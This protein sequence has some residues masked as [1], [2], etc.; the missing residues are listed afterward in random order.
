MK[1][2]ISLIIVALASG[3]LLR[4]QS[5]EP[6][7]ELEF[8]MELKVKCADAFQKDGKN[9]IPIVGGVFEGPSIKGTVLPD[10][11]DTQTITQG[12]VELM[13]VYDIRTDDGVV[14]HVR[15]RGIIAGSYFRASPVF[16]APADSRYSWLNDAIFVCIPEGRPDYISLKVYRLK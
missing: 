4:A 13:A 10:G 1:K 7:P 11:A 5:L 12:R 9:I 6:Q 14:I 15:N 16:E 8:V 2:A 3:F